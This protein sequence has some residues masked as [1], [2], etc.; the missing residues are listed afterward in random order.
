VKVLLL[1]IRSRLSKDKEKLFEGE[2][3]ESLK[4]I[5]DLLK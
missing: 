1:K 4:K 3:I 5:D 2:G